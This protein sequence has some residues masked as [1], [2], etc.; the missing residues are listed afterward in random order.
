ML[1]I[2]NSQYDIL[3]YLIE[4]CINLMAGDI[5]GIVVGTLMQVK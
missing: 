4:A 2:E 1:A 3:N 5:I